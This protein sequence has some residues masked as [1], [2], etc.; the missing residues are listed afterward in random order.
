[1]KPPS[2]PA[3]PPITPEQL[4]DA[5]ELLGWSSEHLAARSGTTAY[6]VTKYERSGRVACRQGQ[7]PNFD[8]LASILA[9][10]EAAGIEFTNGDQLGVRRPTL[11][12]EEDPVLITPYQMRRARLIL[13][14]SQKGLSNASNTTVGFIQGYE[15]L[16]RVGR[17]NL[18]R[19]GFDGLAAIHGVLKQAGV[20]FTNGDPPGAR[21]AKSSIE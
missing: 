8:A 19:A 4:R 16:G 13:G 21:L 15:E 7:P 12:N 6:G 3:L 10:L 1:M 18:R 11:M 20:E 17:F 5:R 14:W 9:A 2:K